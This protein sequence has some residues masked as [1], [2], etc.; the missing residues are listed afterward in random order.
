MLTEKKRNTYIGV[1]NGILCKL[2]GY[3]ILTHVPGFATV[4]VVLALVGM[5]L[6]IWG[7][8]NL[9]QDKGYPG[10]LGLLG[11]LSFLGLLILILLPDKRG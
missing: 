4:G 1:G 5:G 2:I 6:F 3:V 11:L 9:C 8:I 10:V 7:C